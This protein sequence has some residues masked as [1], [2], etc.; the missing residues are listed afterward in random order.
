ME[1]DVN[2]PPA[3]TK[4]FA[5]SEIAAF[6]A[7]ANGVMDAG[8]T[9]TAALVSGVQAA[10][11]GRQ[12]VWVEMVETGKLFHNTFGEI[13]ITRDML[14]QADNN[15]DKLPDGFIPVESGEHDSPTIA[16]RV[17]EFEVRDNGQ[18]ASLWGL[19]F[20]NDTAAA[21]IDA[22][23]LESLSIEAA[24]QFTDRNTG[25]DQGFTVFAV[26]LLPPGREFVQGLEPVTLGRSGRLQFANDVRLLGTGNCVYNQRSTPAK[27]SSAKL[28]NKGA[29]VTLAELIEALAGSDD[30]TAEQRQQFAAQL[31]EHLTG[32]EEGV[33]QLA[34]LQTDHA[35]QSETMKAQAAELATAQAKVQE[36]ETAGGDSAVQLSNQVEATAKLSQKLEQIEGDLAKEKQDREIDVI[37]QSAAD[38]LYPWEADT[39][40]VM[41]ANDMD[42]G[43]KYLEQRPPL[44]L[45]NSGGDLIA[46]SPEDVESQRLKFIAQS[47][48]EGM[49]TEAAH[50]AADRKFSGKGN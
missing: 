26:A 34:Q 33:T 50:A 2:N 29:P 9:F 4:G 48:K 1:F 22:G 20:F 25:E 44:Q 31:Q 17:L 36:L 42:A 14:I 10:G 24:P 43:R 23:N 39:I 16:G 37:L 27:P 28:S 41:L 40:R 30:L 45:D 12:M 11:R 18:G 35:A 47:R 15:F 8:G 13:D 3:I 49:S 5:D 46:G 6:V 19:G 32:H 7:A 21:E 38:R